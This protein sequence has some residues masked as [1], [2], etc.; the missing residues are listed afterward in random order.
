[1]TELPLKVRLY[2]ESPTGP[3]VFLAEDDADL[4]S[5]FVSALRRGGYE[6][7]AAEDGAELLSFLSAVAEKRLPR[8]DAIVSDVRMPGH[9]G[10]EILLAL[11][12]AE[13]DV[14]ILLMTAFG[15]A[16]VR[17]RASAFGAA[18]LLEK[19]LTSERL[20]DAVRGALAVTSSPA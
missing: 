16:F 15:D 6:V 19:P 18:A 11:R 7:L 5:L 1:M 8:P 14:P 2:V 9:D 3:R 20:V 17:R 4:R 13:W 12:L 10:M